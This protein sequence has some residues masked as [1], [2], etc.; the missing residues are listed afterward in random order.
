MGDA[1]VFMTLANNRQ[2]CIFSSMLWNVE[3]NQWIAAD[4]LTP[5]KKSLNI[6]TNEQSNK[7]WWNFLIHNKTSFKLLLNLSYYDHHY[8]YIWVLIFF[9]KH[10]LM[11]LSKLRICFPTKKNL[12]AAPRKR[13][14]VLVLCFNAHFIPKKIPTKKV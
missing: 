14:F 13:W 4:K 6:I 9:L 8:D 1:D 5:Q 12:Q 11:F 2:Q 3:K 10:N 7:N